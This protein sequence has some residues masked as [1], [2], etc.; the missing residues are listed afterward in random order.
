MLEMISRD[1]HTHFWNSAVL[2]KA[3]PSSPLLSVRWTK[4]VSSTPQVYSQEERIRVAAKFS[5]QGVSTATK[6]HL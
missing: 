4:P 6:P 3:W 5:C 1:W 2:P